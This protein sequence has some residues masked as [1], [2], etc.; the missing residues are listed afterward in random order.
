[1]SIHALIV[2]IVGTGIFSLLMAILAL[3]S[4]KTE[5]S[6]GAK[7]LGIGIIYTLELVAICVCVYFQL[8]AYEDHPKW[9]QLNDGDNNDGVLAIFNSAVGITTALVTVYG[10]YLLINRD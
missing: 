3:V 6:T 1:M 9:F 10:L 8:I 5:S 2:I 7:L 4:A